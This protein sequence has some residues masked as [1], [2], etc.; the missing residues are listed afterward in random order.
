MNYIEGNWK[1][2]DNFEKL[3]SALK[4]GENVYLTADI[5]CAG[6][7][8]ALTGSYKGILEGNGYTISGLKTEK[9]GT[10]RP[11]VSIFKE[12]G[13]KAEIRNV[14]FTDVSYDFTGIKDNVTALKVAALAV[15]STGAKITNVSVTGTIT[16]N[17]AGEL[18]MLNEAV[19]EPD[20]ATV[21]TEF[22]AD[23]NIVIQN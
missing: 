11:A 14:N 15:T 19:Y 6:G 17:Y 5:D 22:A 3:R 12:L 16:T 1:L 13:D 4:A 10:L 18:L 23:I 2:V 21:V 9:S 8:L 20:G 7:V